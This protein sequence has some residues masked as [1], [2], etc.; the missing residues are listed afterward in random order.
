MASSN[1]TLEELEILVAPP[2]TE[3]LTL[4]LSARIPEDSDVKH[5]MLDFREGTKRRRQVILYSCVNANFF[6][7]FF[8]EAWAMDPGFIKRQAKAIPNAQI[9]SFL[10][11]AAGGR[12]PSIGDSGRKIPQLD[13]QSE[14]INDLFS[15]LPQGKKKAVIEFLS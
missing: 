9:G 13:F 1:F 3:L 5:V 12:K 14:E 11:A 10:L 4:L 7:V 2:H 15:S 8:C 6:P